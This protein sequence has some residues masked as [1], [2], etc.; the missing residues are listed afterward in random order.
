MFDLG[1]RLDAHVVRTDRLRIN[2]KFH[3]LRFFLLHV[4]NECV[5][6]DTEDLEVFFAHLELVNHFICLV[7][8]DVLLPA[9]VEKSL[10]RF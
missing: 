3:A 5:K 6:V 10:V 8:R 1:V 2:L 7:K 4:L 9:E